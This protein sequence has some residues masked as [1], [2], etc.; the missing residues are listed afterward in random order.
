MTVNGAAEPLVLGRDYIIKEES[1]V[2]H[3]KKGKAKVALRGIGNYGGE[4]TITYTIGAKK[5]LWWIGQ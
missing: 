1:Y 3:T 2:N 5:L 4:K